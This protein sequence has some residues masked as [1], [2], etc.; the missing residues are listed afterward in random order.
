MH[1]LGDGTAVTAGL[2]VFF[3]TVLVFSCYLREM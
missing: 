3:T 2:E 1:V